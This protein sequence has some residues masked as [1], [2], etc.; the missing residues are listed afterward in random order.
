MKAKSLIFSSL[1]VLGTTVMYAQ[2]S[3]PATSSS[4]TPASKPQMPNTQPG[5][6][7]SVDPRLNQPTPTNQ[8]D[9]YN[10]TRQPDVYN[11][12]QTNPLGPQTDQNPANKYVT[13]APTGTVQPDTQS[14]STQTNP[15]ERAVIIK[16]NQI[17]NGLRE[18]LQ[19]PT[20][21]GWERSTI[22]LNQNTNQYS[23]DIGTGTSS[24]TFKFDQDG[25]PIQ[26]SDSQKVPE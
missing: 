8:P 16:N 15:S 9:P 17:P 19:S 1:L 3:D 11:P 24:K 12:T 25:N 4:P 14:S 23:I 18:T 22:Y 21:Q 6:A 5:M 20:Y 10:N 13:P 7:P 26:E 2:Q